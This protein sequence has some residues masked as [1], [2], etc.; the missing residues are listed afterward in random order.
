LVRIG[1]VWDSTTDVLA[2]RAGLLVPIGALAFAL[3]TILEAAARSYGGASAGLALVASLIGLAGVVATVWGS[4]AVAAVASDPAMTSAQ[5]GRLAR[6]RLGKGLTVVLVLIGAVI[7]L[8]LPVVIALW[9][10]GFDFRAAAAAQAAG[11]MPAMASG[12]RLFVSLYGLALLALGLWAGARL[13]LLYVVVL[14]E[15]RAVGAFGRSIQITRGMTAKLVGVVLLLTVAYLIA[16]SAVQSVVGLLFRLA[17]G[18]QNVATALFMAAVAGAVVTAAFT[19]LIQVFAA[20]LYAAI[21]AR[22]LA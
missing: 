7:L 6:A 13:F 3:P 10:T 22:P 1:D 20:R 2:G 18:P 17:L 8:T 11:R 21:V 19:T 9:S 5:A 16:L 14:N 15:D 4:L 12:A